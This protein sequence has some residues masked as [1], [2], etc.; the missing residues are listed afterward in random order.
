MYVFAFV[1]LNHPIEVLIRIY[2]TTTHHQVW[3]AK[4]H[5]HQLKKYTYINSKSTHTS[6]QKY[7]YINS[8]TK[9]TSTSKVPLHQLKKYTYINSKSTLTTTQKVHLHQLKKYP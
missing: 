8:K 4:I 7:I 9:L 3:I 6:T 1:E 5:L 2:F